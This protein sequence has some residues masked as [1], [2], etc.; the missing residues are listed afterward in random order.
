MKSS[1]MCNHAT[2]TPQGFVPALQKLLRGLYLSYRNSQELI[3]SLQDLLK[4]LYL[5][6][7]T[8]QDLY[9]SYMKSSGMCN[10]ATETPQGFVPTLQKL[11]RGLYLLPS[12][13]SFQTA[14]FLHYSQRLLNLSIHVS[15]LPSI[16]MQRPL[17]AQ[18]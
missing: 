18:T 7:K 17:D 16:F 15:D 2:E 11:L 13:P 12:E 8:P 14:K 3:S 10:H 5:S 1:G 6:Y 4:G 9:L